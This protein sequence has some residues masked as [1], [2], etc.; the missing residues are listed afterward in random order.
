MGEGQDSLRASCAGL[1]GIRGG[2]GGRGSPLTQHGL[3]A[4]WSCRGFAFF[5][6]FTFILDLHNVLFLLL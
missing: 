5:F 1:K 6:L 2:S 3:L 4:G